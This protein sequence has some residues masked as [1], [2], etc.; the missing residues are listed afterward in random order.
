MSVEVAA[1]LATQ[2]LPPGPV[3]PRSTRA[4]PRPRPVLKVY[5]EG[6]AGRARVEA[7]IWQRYADRFA[8]DVQDWFP[9]L[10]TLE[11]GGD[12]LAAAGYRSGAD[13]LFLE[14]YLDAPVEHCLARYAPNL[15][16]TDIVE[17]GQFAALH[18][19]AGRL[20][21]PLL[22]RHLRDEGFQ[23]AISTVT[24]ELHHLFTRMGMHPLPMAPARAD[25]LAPDHRAVWGTYYDHA[26]VVVAERLSAVIGELKAA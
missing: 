3:R 17:A 25:C 20:L 9:R 26:P 21:V 7:Y 19:G 11:S 22:A 15:P 13:P 1:A 2:P 14:R 12:I 5:A 6:A 18:A 16:R 10:V 24:H 8:A 4:A 23:W